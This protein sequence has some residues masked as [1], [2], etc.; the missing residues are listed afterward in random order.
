MGVA[1]LTT[2]LYLGCGL[3]LFIYE[4]AVLCTQDQSGASLVSAIQNPDIDHHNSGYLGMA[5][6]LYVQ[7]H[8][9]HYKILT[10][11]DYSQK[12]IAQLN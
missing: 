4:R 11:K 7:A 5:V 1:V 3:C 8:L 9:G 2:P 12:P 6:Q 10:Q